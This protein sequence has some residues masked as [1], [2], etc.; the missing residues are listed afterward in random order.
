MGMYSP[1]CISKRFQEHLRAKFE[2]SGAKKPC[3]VP[4]A[5]FVIKFDNS[6]QARVL[7]SSRLG[8]RVIIL[9]SETR[10]LTIRDAPDEWNVHLECTALVKE[11]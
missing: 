4:V 11:F 3:S 9:G 7:K 5:A 1:I 10:L 6:G 8:R 2:N